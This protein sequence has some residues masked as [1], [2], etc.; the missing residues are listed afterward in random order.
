MT[1]LLL[2]GT[3]E[4][5]QIA[6]GLSGGDVPVLASLAGVTRQPERL[7]VPTRIGRFGGSDGF[8]KEIK[9]KGITSVLDATHPFANQITDR[10]SRICAQIDLPYA[11][12]LRPEWRPE[13]N[14]EWT[15]V[16]S[17]TDVAAHLPT[18]A[19]VFLA[20]GRQTLED[21]R[22]MNVSGALV[23]VIDP[24]TAP[25]PFS[26]GEFIIGRPPFTPQS[27]AEL[28]QKLGVTH[29]VVKNAGGGGGRAK[30]IAARRLKIPVLMIRRPQMPNVFRV[31]NVLDAI[32]WAIAQ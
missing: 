24:P 5:R 13:P 17:A 8:L 23:R 6:V 14:D 9:L 31:T 29:L 16:N 3:Q 27:E 18:N 20:T 12:V 30:L 21:Y 19:K 28:F 26:G 1:I 15:D 22:N 32:D 2:A 7:P 25:L 4:A 10:T 11:Q